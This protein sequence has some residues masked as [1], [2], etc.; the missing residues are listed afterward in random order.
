MR[1]GTAAF[2]AVLLWAPS[3]LAADLP[4]KAKA[5]TAI[6]SNWGGSY[7][8]LSLG[9]RWSDVGWTTTAVT[10]FAVDPTSNIAAYASSSVRVGG[11]LG[12]Q[13][14]FAPQWVGGVEADV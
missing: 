7:A 2:A 3:A 12:R 8:G 6:T 10:G 13:W 1:Q 11:Y 4:V 5:P 9:G 14:Q